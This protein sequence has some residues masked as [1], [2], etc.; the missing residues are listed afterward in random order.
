[1]TTSK[2]SRSNIGLYFDTGNVNVQTNALSGS[3]SDNIIPPVVNPPGFK[4]GSD[5]N[6]T[7]GTTFHDEFDPSGDN[8]GDTSSTDP[9]VC[10]NSSNQVVSCSGPGVTQTFTSTQVVTVEIHDFPCIAPTG[11]NQLVLPNC[12]SWQ[13]P[14]KT[15]ACTTSAPFYPY[16]FNGLPLTSG[17]HRHRQRVLGS[18]SKCNLVKPSLSGLLFRRYGLSL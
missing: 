3:C 6:V 17:G 5:T 14:G 9:T 18:P 7:C 13:V 11:T 12:T 8:C 16:P 1:M 2:S 4:C 10:L 15:L